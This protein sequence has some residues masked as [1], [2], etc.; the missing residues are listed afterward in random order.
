VTTPASP[1]AP[2]SAPPVC[3]RHPDRVSYVRCQRCGRPAC[4]ECQRPAA[5][6]VHCVDCVREAARQLPA[7]RTIVGAKASQGPPV[8]TITL[9]ALCVVSFVI[10]MTSATWTNDLVFAPVAGRSEPYRFLTAAFLH[11]TGFIPHLIFNM[12]ALWFLGPFLEATLGR[13]RYLSL[14]LLS[15]I[16]GNV[17]VLL[18]ADPP[19]VAAGTWYVGVLGAS[20]AI[21]GV[22][23]AA[24]L[25]LRRLG[26]SARTM[27]VVI[28]LNLVISFTVPGI[29]WQGHVGGLIVGTA[30]GAAYVF[31]P[32]ALR[33]PIAIG[34]TAGVAVLLVALAM[35]RYSGVG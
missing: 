1:A 34:A 28:A 26:Q 14:Y 29:S 11:A 6:G 25:M 8:V 19:S 4:P 24:L 32:R 20:G 17:L 16:G 2:S 15:A 31:A 22:F 7:Q 27:F 3:P 35:V 9:I 5:V 18:L 10:Q 12:V 33:L 13:W 23:G 30:L 21:F